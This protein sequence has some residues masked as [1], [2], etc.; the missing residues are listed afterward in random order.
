MTREKLHEKVKL[1]ESV[2]E[3]VL[4]ANPDSSHA[5]SVISMGSGEAKSVEEA[6]SKIYSALPAELVR[7]GLVGK[8]AG[9][10]KKR[11]NGLT[12]RVYGKEQWE[13]A[14]GKKASFVW[15]TAVY[16][17]QNVVEVVEGEKMKKALVKG[18]A[19]HLLT[20]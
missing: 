9:T 11:M 7:I 13:S 6:V 18:F 1:V 17:H 19:H 8:D 5:I 20:E 14:H 10:L 3:N 12:V 16:P 2:V 15:S 4:Q